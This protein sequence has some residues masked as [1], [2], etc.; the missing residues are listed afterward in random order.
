MEKDSLDSLF[1]NLQGTF[2]TEA[3]AIGHQQRFLEKLDASK[4]ETSKSKKSW[5]KPLAVAASLALLCTIGYGVF[6]SRPTLDQQVAE[7]SPEVSRT[8]FYFAGLIEEQVE[9]LEKESSPQTRR[10]IDDSM[11]QLKK[12]EADYA[13]LEQDLV[14]GGNSKLLLSA[15]ITNFQT[16]IDLLRAVMDKIE[17]LKNLKAYDDTN[18]TI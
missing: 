3:P 1:E 18:T 14:K 5:W 2:D 4:P 12:L 7:I 6:E 8:Q 17:S 15:M 13:R 9:T 10:I 16:R 11:V